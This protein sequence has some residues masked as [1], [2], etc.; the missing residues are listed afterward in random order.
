M[1]TFILHVVSILIAEQFDKTY[2]VFAGKEQM[3]VPRQRHSGGWRYNQ[4]D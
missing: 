2:L 1:K 4:M 3:S